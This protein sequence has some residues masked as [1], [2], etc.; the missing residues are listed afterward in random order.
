MPKT[1]IAILLVVIIG[2]GYWAFSG[3]VSAPESMPEEEDPGK[4]TVASKEEAIKNLFAQKYDKEASAITLKI[5][6][7]TDSHVRGGVTLPPGGSENSGLF[8]AAKT[9]G[10][11]ELV[12]DGQGALPCSEIE[13]YNFPVYMATECIDQNAYND[14]T[15]MEAAMLIEMKPE[16]IIIDVSPHYEDGHLP[17]AVSYYVGD[18]SLDQAIPILEK[19]QEYLVYCHVDSAAILGAQKLIDAGFNRVYRLEGNYSAWVGAGYPVEIELERVGSIEG[20]MVATRSYDGETFEHTVTGQIEE[21]PSDKFYEGWLVANTPSLDFFSTGE[22]EEEGGTFQLEYITEQ[23]V[24]D[25]NQVVITLE[26]K[27]SG[28]DGVPEDHLF[29]GEF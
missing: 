1:I 28:L 25:H 20:T 21:P 24:R 17:G 10:N 13:S 16:M 22:L 11:W 29:E 15:P 9:N 27:E 12:F 18:G 3:P 23:D 8:L 7:G 2:V 5:S 4:E 14:V 26:T 19:N 6:Q